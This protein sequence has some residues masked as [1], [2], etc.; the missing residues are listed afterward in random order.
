METLMATDR[1]W[2]ESQRAARSPVGKEKRREAA[3]LPLAARVS[4]SKEIGTVLINGIISQVH[5]DIVLGKET[6]VC[7]VRRKG[8]LPLLLCALPWPLG[9][10]EMEKKG[11]VLGLT[12]TGKT[13]EVR[14]G[15]LQPG[16]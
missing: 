10:K 1:V 16:A 3:S 4:I 11:G 15:I 12:Y 14:R 7:G 13:E 9:L 2:I 8:S 6:Q 5:A